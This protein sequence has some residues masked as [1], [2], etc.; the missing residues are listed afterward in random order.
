MNNYN[1]TDYP[2]KDNTKP[3]S[4]FSNYRGKFI[5]HK[6][7]AEVDRARF[8]LDTFDFTWMC[9]CRFVSKVNLYVRGY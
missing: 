6:C 7:K 3:L 8:W 1:K 5:C 4:K 9:E 2:K